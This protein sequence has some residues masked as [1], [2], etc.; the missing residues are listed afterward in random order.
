MPHYFLRS[1]SC[2]YPCIARPGGRSQTSE[3][4]TL[5]LAV[6]NKK[7]LLPVSTSGNAWPFPDWQHYFVLPDFAFINL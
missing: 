7:K 6:R 3:A 1:L 4:K 5:H 2:M